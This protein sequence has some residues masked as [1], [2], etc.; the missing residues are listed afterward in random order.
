MKKDLT[1]PISVPRN[2]RSWY[3]KQDK[4]IVPEADILGLYSHFVS[5]ELNFHFLS[6]CSRVSRFV[7]DNGLLQKDVHGWI[8]AWR[9]ISRMRSLPCN[10]TLYSLN[11]H[12]GGH[13]LLRIGWGAFF[14]KMKKEKILSSDDIAFRI[15]EET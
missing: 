12:D 1:N 5:S 13:I 15:P 7:R 3:G 11:P 6:W 2:P 4:N 14:R 8:N 9:P 10:Y